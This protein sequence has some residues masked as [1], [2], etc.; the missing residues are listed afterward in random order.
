M[1]NPA[2]PSSPL[3]RI[4]SLSRSG[5]VFGL[6]AYV[7]WG[8][9]PVYFISVSPTGPFELVALRVLFSIVFCAL[10][11]TVTRS[12]PALVSI[13]RNPRLLFTMGGA[14]VLIY[15]NW[16][17]YAWAVLNGRVLEAALGYFINPIFTIF[18]GV[19]VR[20]ES[21]RPAQWTAVVVS[22]IAVVVLAVNYGSFPWISLAL[23]CSFGCYGLVKKQIGDR[24][25][26]LSGLTM[27]TAWLVPVAVIQLA[28]V[29]ATSGLTI[30]N[31]STGHTILLLASGVLTAVPLLFFAAAA[32]R[33]PLVYMG[34]IQYLAPLMQ[35]ALGAFI[36]AEPMP[37]GRWVGFALV[38]LA[39]VVLTVDMLRTGLGPRKASLE[40]AA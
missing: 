29:G 23:A 4:G 40:P 15:V 19:F 17:V 18:L 37:A 39:L 10:L 5:L 14:A 2:S 12:W 35:F 30:G 32:R 31:V 27:E 33:L 20:R 26:A 28:I 25:D 36:L 13:C 11:I 24:V 6:L 22:G 34:L 9:L 7:S 21:L 3:T 1:P 38:W 16:Q 8:I